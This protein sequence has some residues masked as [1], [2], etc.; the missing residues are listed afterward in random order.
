MLRSIALLTACLLWQPVQAKELLVSF[1]LDK[2]PF[3]FRDAAGKPS[4]IEI[5]IMQMALTRAGYA[6]KVNAIS[7]VRLV[8]SVKAG[9]ADIAVS[10]PSKGDGAVFY[11]DKL[12][13]YANVVISRKGRA[14]TIKRLQDLDDISFVIWQRGWADL[15]SEFEAKYK[16]DQNGQFRRNY[17]EGRTQEVQVRAYLA[18]RADAIVI[19]RTIFAWYMRELAPDAAANDPLVFHNVFKHSTNYAAVFAD[20]AVRDRFNVALKSL[21]ADG[22]YQAILKKYK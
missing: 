22:S 17:F 8:W 10:V 12:F 6:M 20:K 14:L 11:S 15:G 1:N 16:P 21:H 18:K 5:D 9:Q 19:D 13:E 4:G 7:R 3:T 2:P